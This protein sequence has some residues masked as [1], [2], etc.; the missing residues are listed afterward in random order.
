[1]N[2]RVAKLSIAALGL[3]ILAISCAGPAKLARQSHRE[4]ARGNA[5]NAYDL[6][7]RALDK[8]SKNHDAQV[9]FE[10]ASQA[11]AAEW[12]ERIEHAAELDTISAARAVLEFASF[13]HEAV[14]YGATFPRDT[15]FEVEQSRLKRG[16]AAIYYGL[17][18]DSLAAGNAR[19]AYH[20]FREASSFDPS[21]RDVEERMSRAHELAI[22]RVAVLPFVNQ[23]SVP[24]LTGMIGDRVMDLLRPHLD[25]KH[26]EFTRLIDPS[27]VDAHV[28][29]AQLTELSAE[30]AMSL[31]RRLGADV[32][33]RGRLFGEHVTNNNDTYRESIFHHVTVTDSSG[34]HQSEFEEMPFVATR[35]E[36][37]VQV[38][39][40]LEALGT[41]NE[42]VIARESDQVQA[43]ADAIYTDF[44]SEG[45]CRDYRLVSPAL[46]KSDLDRA[47]KIKD[48]WKRVCGPWSL[49]SMLEYSRRHPNRHTYQASYRNEFRSPER[50]VFLGELPS[51]GDLSLI[52]LDD[53]WKPVLNVLEEVEHEGVRGSDR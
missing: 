30:D 19:S 23:T 43:H 2:R 50:P 49:T 38:S 33:V 35:R 47:E 46:E 31:G 12:R 17:A 9:A 8:D 16:A 29:V 45:D 39:Y 48:E 5:E 20:E 4:L 42:E 10:D 51:E 11:L 22:V 32:V 3:V 27:R 18:Q 53:L 36:R 15:A 7:R 34:K 41:E 28:S 1:M 37:I 44:V 52:A 14:R 24:G 40:E 26:F 6:A 13:R 21:Y 25:A